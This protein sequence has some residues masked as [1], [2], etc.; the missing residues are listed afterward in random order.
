MANRDQLAILRSGVN[1]WN[2]WKLAH[3]AETPDLNQ[4]DLA[5]INLSGANLKGARLIEANFNRADLSQVNL[6]GA[7]LNRA[8]LN[9]TNLNRAQL[10]GV[11]IR[12]AQLREAQLNDIQASGADFSRAHLNAARLVGA[13]LIGANLTAADLSQADLSQTDFSFVALSRTIFVGTDHSTVI[14]LELCVHHAPSTLD[15]YTIRKSGQLPLTFLRGVGLP[16]RVLNYLPLPQFYA[17]FLSYSTKDQ[18]FAERLYNDLQEQGVR[19]WYA[20]EDIQGGKKIYEQ[21]D[22]AIRLHDKLLLILSEA[23][24]ASTWVEHELRRARRRE[25]REGRRVLFPIRLIDY[26]ALRDWEL[27]DAD[28][29]K[30]LATEIREY[31]IPDFSPWKQDHHAYQRSFDHLLRDLRAEGAAPGP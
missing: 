8:Q 25:V 28:T 31:F 26:E 18:A 15:E 3:P 29:G 5:E 20:P 7:N 24:I 13:N 6:S 21:I 30:D 27:F 19:C 17:C 16:D 14:G 11:N 12:A 4:V 1:D 22:E 10:H 9:K 2:A 23:S